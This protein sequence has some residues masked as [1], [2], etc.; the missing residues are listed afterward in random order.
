MAYQTSGN[1]AVFDDDVV[2]FADFV[3]EV[4]QQLSTD[5]NNWS[6]SIY[7]NVKKALAKKKKGEVDS[8]EVQL[9][10]G[11]IRKSEA[12]SA[13]RYVGIEDHQMHFL[14]LPFY[15][16]GKVRKKP[17]GQDDIQITTDFIQQIKP[18]Q[19]YAC[20]LYTSPSPRGQI[21]SRMPSSA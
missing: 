2:K 8:H 21:G 11:L 17:I 19:I 12:K 15:E 7:Q 13:C 3:G 9:I 20:L 10:K 6:N 16:T 1:I 5:T 14:N 18:H 4:D